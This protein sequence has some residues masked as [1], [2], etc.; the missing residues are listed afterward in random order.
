MNLLSLNLN[1]EVDELSI[2]LVEKRL[3]F[4]LYWRE[5]IQHN[6]HLDCNLTFEQH[7]VA[8][9]LS[10]IFVATYLSNIFI[11]PHLTNICVASHLG[12]ICII[13]SNS[14]HFIY[15]V[16]K[17][18]MVTSLGLVL[19]SWNSWIVCTIIGNNQLKHCTG[20]KLLLCKHQ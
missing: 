12:N 1:F 5:R 20:R 19:C 16:H 6:H 9:Y 7:F 10:N 13:W 8:S 4:A 18:G 3:H 17:H 2:S 11:D 15:R 14:I